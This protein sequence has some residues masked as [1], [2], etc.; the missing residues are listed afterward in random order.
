[1]PRVTI[2]DASVYHFRRATSNLVTLLCWGTIAFFCLVQTAWSQP[3]GR[4]NSTQR[5]VW[6]QK[7]DG[8]IQPIATGAAF[9]AGDVL[10]TGRDSV[11]QLEFSDGSMVALRPNSQLRVERYSYRLEAPKLDNLVL[12]LVK[13][14]LRA[15]T[16]LIGKRGNQDAYRVGG[17]TATIGVRGTEFTARLC[18]EDC[19]QE[20]GKLPV[21]DRSPAPTPAARIALA[22]GN[23]WA[24]DSK[25]VTRALVKKSAVYQGDVVR[26]APD[27]HALLLFR[28]EGRL[29]VAGNSAVTIEQ[30]RYDRTR[31]ESNSM[32]LRLLQGGLRSLTGLIAKRKPENFRIN[33]IIAT[34]GV[35]GTGLDIRCTGACSAGGAV[36]RGSAG[37]AQ[38]FDGGRAGLFVQAWIG[39]G[40]VAACDGVAVNVEMGSTVFL[41]DCQAKPQFVPAPA[42]VLFDDNT[43]RPDKIQVDMQEQFP[44]GMS[45]I[46]P[47]LYVFV[48]SGAVALTDAGADVL[49][50]PGMAAYAND[51]GGIPQEIE[52]PSFMKFDPW[53]PLSKNICY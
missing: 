31:P 29:T 45:G 49:I 5:L 18:G 36:A 23:V 40:T 52:P 34:I 28:D 35:R 26:T 33:T 20:A 44:S 51:N 37:E 39:T 43:P 16:G 7:P 48:T 41:A 17:L 8:T 11:A 24:V 6:L 22:Q 19:A 14:G 4:V 47:G 9:D 42:P 1:M 10:S 13:G 38:A 46:D 32:A 25:G 53:L 15:V 3:A 21:T 50:E 12:R 2:L 27:A 30:Y